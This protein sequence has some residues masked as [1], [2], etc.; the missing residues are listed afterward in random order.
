[1]SGDVS[2]EL[3]SAI[4]YAVDRVL[5]LFGKDA[6]T[7]SA[8]ERIA[9]RIRLSA[10]TAGA[11]QCIGMSRPIP[12]DTIYQPTRLARAQYGNESGQLTAAD[13]LDAPGDYVVIGPPGAG[14]T[15]LLQKLY[16]DLLA[17]KQH[18][19]VLFILRTTAAVDDLVAFIKD[20]RDLP[21]RKSGASAVALLIDGYDEISVAQ[22]KLVSEQ[23]KEFSSLGLGRY[24]LTCRTHFDIIDLAAP[25]L[26]IEPFGR[27]DAQR[28][29]AAFLSAYQHHFDAATLIDELIERGFSDFLGSPLMLTL[30]C[31]LKTGP[32]KTLPRNTIGLIRRALDTLTFRWDESRGIEREGDAPLDGEERVRC[33]M[34]IAHAFESPLGPETT[35]VLMSSKSSDRPR[36]NP[37]ADRTGAEDRYRSRALAQE[38]NRA[39]CSNLVALH[40]WIRT[41]ILNG[42]HG[43]HGPH[44]PPSAATQRQP[45]L[46]KPRKMCGPTVAEVH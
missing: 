16:F 13:L 5:A 42:P 40:L 23:L 6:L 44:G 3:G 15:V 38:S 45:A 7:A 26:Y 32:L 27:E 12:I 19:P 17:G 34:R 39:L 25:H 33:L 43:P 4:P 41:A 30:V 28:Y 29:V 31:I 2:I 18:T 46:K 8:R 14:K 36:P 35:A 22:R 37:G 21:P 1:M 11:V 10:R 24:L 20:L 9:S